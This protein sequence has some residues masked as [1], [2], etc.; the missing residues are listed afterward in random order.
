MCVTVGGNSGWVDRWWTCLLSECQREEVGHS[1]LS[2]D[3]FHYFTVSIMDKREELPDSLYS[4]SITE[5]LMF[6]FLKYTACTVV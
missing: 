2:F 3:N 6:E 4:N 1:G 5:T